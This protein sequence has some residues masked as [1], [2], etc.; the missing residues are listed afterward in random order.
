MV[1]PGRPTR[2]EAL[3]VA[4]PLIC[5]PPGGTMRAVGL[6]LAARKDRRGSRPPVEETA[7]AVIEHAADAII[8]VRADR[9]VSVWNPAAERMFGWTAAEVVGLQ[10]PFIPEELMAEH[11]AVLE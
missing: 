7:R 8:A 9:T 6:R 4:F 3:H 5:G 10:P 2:C 1:P 11:N